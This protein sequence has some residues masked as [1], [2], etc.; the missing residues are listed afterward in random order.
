MLHRNLRDT[1]APRFS[2][3]A[4][5]IGLLCS[6]LL[7]AQT[8]VG[9]GSIV[10]TVTHQSGAVVSGAKITITNAGT[11]QKIDATTNSAGAYNSGVL[12]PGTYK[13][14]VSSKGFS[15]SARKPRF[16]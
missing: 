5:L 12:S 6:T 15:S 14:Q 13:V 11:G 1:S 8:T 2:P 10:G 4:V 3:I 9:T 16:W 7:L